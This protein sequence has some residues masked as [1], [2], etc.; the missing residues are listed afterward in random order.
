M[1]SETEPQLQ[2]ITELAEI[3]RL[4]LTLRRALP[5]FVQ[6]G[7]ALRKQP[8]WVAVPADSGGHLGPDRPRLLD[9]L[10]E[11][12]VSSFYAVPVDLEIRPSVPAYR[13]RA[14]ARGIKAVDQE[15]SPFSYAFFAGHPDWCILGTVEDY[16]VVAGPPSFVR[17]F[18]RTTPADAFRDFYTLADQYGI[19]GRSGAIIKQRL[20]RVYTQLHDVYPRAKDHEIIPLDAEA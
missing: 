17:T 2:V 6:D 19:A 10:R 12:G 14:T 5:G 1:G 9:A 15:T 13:V 4:Q 8:G 7:F 16:I 18:C 20:L 11:H 3:S